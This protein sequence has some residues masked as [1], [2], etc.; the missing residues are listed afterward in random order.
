M[1]VV[2]DQ[3]SHD[4][5]PLHLRDQVAR[6]Q[7]LCAL[8]EWRFNAH[9]AEHVPMLLWQGEQ[10]VSCDL[11]VGTIDGLVT[12]VELLRH[13][14]PGLRVDFHD[15]WYLLFRVDPEWLLSNVVKCEGVLQ[16][17]VEQL[18]WQVVNSLRK[19]FG[20]CSKDALCYLHEWIHLRKRLGCVEMLCCRFGCVARDLYRRSTSRACLAVGHRETY[21]QTFSRYYGEGLSRPAMRTQKAS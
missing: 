11:V 10:P 12:L 19:C 18:W 14:V 21:I 8:V 2:G 3:L 4:V 7:S 6:V 16:Y 5:A 9:L 15:V 17:L 1:S 20:S 13:G